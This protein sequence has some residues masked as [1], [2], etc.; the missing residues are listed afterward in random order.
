MKKAGIDRGKIRR[1][2][3]AWVGVERGMV[4]RVGGR[5]G[6]AG[7]TAELERCLNRVH[8]AA[9]R[10]K[11]QSV[12]ADVTRLAWASESAVRL[13]VTW[14]MWIAAEPATKRYVLTFQID[15]L[16]VWQRATFAAL[17]SIVP[18]IAEV[19]TRVP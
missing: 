19:T 12:V 13:F 4:L 5:L 2:D 3:E 11:K 8:R 9:I 15:A 7:A 14:A 17:H 16:S 10:Y 1:I 6:S 18:D